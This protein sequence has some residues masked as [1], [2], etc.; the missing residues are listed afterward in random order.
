MPSPSASAKA[1]ELYSSPDIVSH[2]A[3]LDYLTPC[4]SLLFAKYIQPGMNVLDV[5]VGGGRTT[6]FL[7]GIARQYVGVDSSSAMVL[8]AQ[9]R[10][11][12]TVFL[13]TTASDLGLFQ[14]SSFD[15]IVMAFNVLDHLTDESER[16]QC[17][18][19]CRRVL[20]T[21]GI[22]IFSSHNPRAF[23]VRGCW[24]PERVK[25]YARRWVKEES[26]GF[27]LLVALL[28]VAK[29]MINGTRALL[30]TFGRIRHRLGRPA[31]WTG[32]GCI[33]DQMHGGVLI[34]VGT[35]ARVK[36]E[37][38]NNGFHTLEMLGDDYP[39]HSRQW[40]TD[41]YYYVGR[42]EETHQE[43]EWPTG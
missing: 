2:Y 14:D 5:G 18:A 35:P 29:A 11:P 37:L 12:H 42:A 13:R 16:Q 30:R 24:S 15:C 26:F 28:T 6:A 7:S 43:G 40:I 27:P 9:Q 25:A 1:D 22:L 39:R 31:F 3:G 8:R 38:R 32:S 34:H 19:E 36:D 21:D 20:A 41:W 23:L 4:E 17:F 33:V 10:F